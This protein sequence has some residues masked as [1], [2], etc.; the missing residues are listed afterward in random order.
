MSQQNRDPIR[1]LWTMQQQTSHT[2]CREVLI[3]NNLHPIKEI[4]N[5]VTLAT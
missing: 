2:E 3:S 4:I 1:G 5:Q